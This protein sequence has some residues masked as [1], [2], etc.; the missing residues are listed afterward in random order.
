LLEENI[1]IYKHR[2]ILKL[3]E[4][5]EVLKGERSVNMKKYKELKKFSDKYDP[6]K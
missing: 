2:K 5:D 4:A 3:K 1:P 6:E